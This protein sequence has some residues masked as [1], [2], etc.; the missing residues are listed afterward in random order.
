[1]S[2]GQSSGSRFRVVLDAN[3]IISG[4][5]FRGNE[6]RILNYGKEGK[7]AVGLSQ[8]IL[9]EVSGV[10]QRRFN[11][12]PLAAQAE[13]DGLLQ[14]AKMVVPTVAVQGVC[15]DADDD[16]ILECSLQAN[17]NYLVT[18]DRDL[19]VLNEFRGAVIVSG[20]EFLRIYEELATGD[21]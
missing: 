11:Y 16:R 3:V 18:G 2:T 12:S 13:I 21:D 20:A 6:Y 10:L 5:R 15:R 14:W 4:I 17:A 7:I 8:H 19:L 1:M 9:E